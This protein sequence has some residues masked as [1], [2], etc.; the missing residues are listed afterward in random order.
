MKP[1]L[2]P[3]QDLNQLLESAKTAWQRYKTICQI[4]HHRFALV[5]RGNDVQLGQAPVCDLLFLQQLRDYAVNGTSKFDDLIGKN[6]HYSFGRT[7]VDELYVVM[8]KNT[9][10]IPGGLSVVAIDTSV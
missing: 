9:G 8:H 7:A 1:K 5:H 6:A 4:G 2:P 10:K 3:G